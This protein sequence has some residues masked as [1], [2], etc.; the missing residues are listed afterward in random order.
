M[1]D[2]E[3]KERANAGEKMWAILIDPD[4]L[5]FEDITDFI[6]MV[7]KSSCDFILIGGSL[8][9]HGF[10]DKYVKKIKSLTSK[11]IIIFPG[12]NLQLSN[13]ADGLLFLSLIS[14]R[15]PDLL[16]GQHVKVAQQV[17]Q[18]NVCVMP[19]GYMLIESNK[20]TSAIYMSE[21]LPIPNDKPDIAAATAL[22]GTLLGMQFLYI[23]TGSGADGTIKSNLIRAV[24]NTA[25]VPLFVG[26]GIHKQDQLK[27]AWSSGADIVVIGTSIEK[28]YNQ[29]FDFKKE[30]IWS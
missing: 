29:M 4:K 7:N 13:H 26:G 3:I 1:I 16:I 27:K 17:Q 19:C 15:N 22:A 6:L 9:N 11:K 5:P 24:K 8:I 30:K 2:V 28:S 21:S 12:N 14:G 20:L 10:F 18:S 23:D 25:D